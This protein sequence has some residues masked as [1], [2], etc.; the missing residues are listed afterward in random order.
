[1]SGTDAEDVFARSGHAAR[2]A[3]LQTVFTTPDRYGRGLDWTGYTIYDATGILL[4]YLKSLTEPVIPYHCYDLFTRPILAHQSWYA[5]QPD[6]QTTQV[7]EDEWHTKLVRAY[8]D[9]IR[10][11]PPL[12]RQLLVYLI[13]LLALFASKSD[14]NKMT[15]NRLACT[16]NPALVSRKPA[17]MDETQ[18][19]L[20]QY[21]IIFLI[22]N[23]DHFLIGMTETEEASL[24]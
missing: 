8:Q 14:S 24:L 4:R 5:S 2:I 16:F 7:M 1:V 9:C 19:R 20:A 10:E 12:N 3:N 6:G 15:S 11:L 22:E 13:D 23:Q 18:H 21:V 17:E